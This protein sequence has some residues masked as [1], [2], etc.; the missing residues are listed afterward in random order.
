VPEEVDRYRFAWIDETGLSNVIYKLIIKAGQEPFVAYEGSETSWVP[1]PEQQAAL[2]D[3]IE[4][5]VELWEPNALDYSERS[6]WIIQVR[7]DRSD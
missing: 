1:T 3:R 5:K 4:W 7:Q 6:A 2:P